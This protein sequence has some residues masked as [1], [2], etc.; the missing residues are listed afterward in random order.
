[1]ADKSQLP[2]SE[3]PE[4]ATAHPPADGRLSD[5]TKMMQAKLEDRRAREAEI[6]V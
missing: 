1:M 4:T 6:W 3:A 2:L 5:L